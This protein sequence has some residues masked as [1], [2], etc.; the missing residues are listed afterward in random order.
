LAA[1]YEKDAEKCGEEDAPINKARCQKNVK[2]EK[3]Y[4]E[5][6]GLKKGQIGTG[7]ES[8]TQCFF[9]PLHPHPGLK[10]HHWQGSN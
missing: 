9:N 6:E 4:H 8:P 7:W 3:K 1:L 2:K 10:Q 5:Y